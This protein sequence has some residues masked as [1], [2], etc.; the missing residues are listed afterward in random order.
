MPTTDVRTNSQ[1]LADADLFHD[2][3][4]RRAA[5]TVA[6]RVTDPA[7]RDELLECL[8]LVEA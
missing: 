5:R 2:L 6:I 8:G 1:K 4:K 7:A 3:E